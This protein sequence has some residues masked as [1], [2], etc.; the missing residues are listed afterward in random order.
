VTSTVPP[1]AE[2]LK[3]H[4]WNTESVFPNREAWEQEVEAIYAD[5]P[6]LTEQEGQLGKSPKHLA[7]FLEAWSLMSARADKMLT[8]GTLV[9]AIDMGNQEGVS[10]NDRCRTVSTHV[11]AA[12][13]FWQPEVIEIGFDTLH[14]WM[15]REPRLALYAHKFNEL[16][17]L[18]AHVRNAEVEALLNGLGE[19]FR[20]TTAT[21]GILTDVDMPIPSVT[22]NDEQVPV[23]QGNISAHLSNSDRKVR[24]AAWEQYADAHLTYKNTIANVVMTGVKQ[25]VYMAKARRFGSALEAAL[26]ANFIP[27]AVFYNLIATFRKNL[28]LW[29]RYWRLRKRVLGL[30]ELGVWDIK[31]PLSGEKVPV[32]YEQSIAWICEG[33][34]PLGQ[35][36]VETMRRGSLEERWV[37]IYSNRGK[38]A[39][40]FSSGSY[41]TAPF[42]LM[43]YNNDLFSLSTL[44]H[45]LGHS[46]HSYYSRASQPYAYSRYSIFVA[47]VASN[48]NQ[49]LT[50]D[51]LLKS[52]SDDKAFQIGVIEEA[53]ANFHRYFFIMPILAQFELELHERAWRGE[54]VT[55]TD[56]IA[57]MTKLFHEGYGNEVAIDHDRIG[58]TWAQFPTH[59]YLNFY[60]Y[61]YATG[62]SGANALAER[63]LNGEAGAAEAYLGFLKAGSSRYPLDALQEAGVDLT[64]PA[65]VDAAF[66]VMESYIERLER[67]LS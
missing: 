47:E 43:S 60:V 42:I 40:A 34:E 22:M 25:N 1:R 53:M 54:G 58:I 50:R 21:H 31:A 13:A 67:L 6:A 9:N 59:M 41:G 36:Y 15:E 63:V 39:G 12:L 24:Q 44:A 56:M 16:E 17:R 66:K 55:A 65:P 4:T 3:A 62:I 51:Y 38:R 64:S 48:F 27:K 49:A 57:H 19:A 28:P 5:L 45:E 30:S 14:D 10:I 33:M 37:D 46:M 11:R 26:A 52:H 29:H 35:E 7:T 18:Q 32:S 61:M 2:I 23:A 8:Y 20:G